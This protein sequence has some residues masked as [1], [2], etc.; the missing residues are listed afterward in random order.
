MLKIM[1]R[2]YL[3]FYAENLCLSKP[4]FP[5]H[6]P[7]PEGDVENGVCYFITNFFALIIFFF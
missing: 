1:V 6:L 5:M 7:G 2:K 3:Q 4:V